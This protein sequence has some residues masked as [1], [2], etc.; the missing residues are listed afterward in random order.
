[1]DYDNDK[2]TLKNLNKGFS[3][4]IVFKKEEEKTGS[5]FLKTKIR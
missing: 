5:I 1:M 4:E 2:K 3:A